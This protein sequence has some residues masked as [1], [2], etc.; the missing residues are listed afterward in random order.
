MK[1]SELEEGSFGDWAARQGYMGKSRQLA[2]TAKRYQELSSSVSERVFSDKLAGGLQSAIASGMVDETLPATPTQQVQ[3]QKQKQRQK[4]SQLAQGY[5]AP[6][7]DASVN[8][9]GYVYKYSSADKSWKTPQGKVVRGQQDIQTLNKMYYDSQQGQTSAVPE[10]VYKEFES[11]LEQKLGEAAG[12][13]SIAQW[14]IRFV[15]N[16]IALERL[17]GLDAT[18]MNQLKMLAERFQLAYSRTKPQI[19]AGEV[20]KLYAFLDS[21]SLTHSTERAERAQMQDTEDELTSIVRNI[22]TSNIDGS[23]N[24]SKLAQNVSKLLLYLNKINPQ[25]SQA[26]IQSYSRNAGGNS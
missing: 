20:K 11:L 6:S 24:Y 3:Q 15:M 14:I 23:D 4:Q 21:W 17:P 13:M 22:G 8:I 18:G 12:A 9:R 2:A 1:K 19:P 25:L 10:S 16:E 26:I 7:I 5:A